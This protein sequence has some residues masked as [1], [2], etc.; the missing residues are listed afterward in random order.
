MKS[1]NSIEEGGF[2]QLQLACQQTNQFMAKQFQTEIARSIFKKPL[3]RVM[4]GFS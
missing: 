1:I 3:L 2:R 4:D